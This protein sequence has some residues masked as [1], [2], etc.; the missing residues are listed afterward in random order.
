[1]TPARRRI[2]AHRVRAKRGSMAG[3][4]VF[5]HLSDQIGGSRSALWATGCSDWGFRGLPT[6]LSE[7]H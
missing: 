6:Q 7:I 2:G 4:G 1:M 5:R 3:S